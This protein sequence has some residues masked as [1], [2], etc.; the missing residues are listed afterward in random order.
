MNPDY[1]NKQSGMKK[2]A[3]LVVVLII[4]VGLLGWWLGRSDKPSDTASNDLVPVSTASED[5]AEAVK[6]LVSYALPDGWQE[7][8]CKA[9]AGSVYVRPAGADDV[10]CNANPS[11]DVKISI[12]PESTKDCNELQSVQNV[13]KHVCISLY[14]NGLRSL[15]ATTEYLASSS[16]G[17]DTTVESYYVDTGKGVIKAEYFYNSENRFQ[18]SFDQ[19]ANSIN[20]KN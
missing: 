18:T 2:L 15:K 17:R 11:S 3:P 4:V 8:S 13:K 12:D 16:Y 19:L 5:D 1:D 9:A 20:V 6:S 10:D 14:I 7:E